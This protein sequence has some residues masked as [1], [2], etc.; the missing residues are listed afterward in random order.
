MSDAR[1]YTKVTRPLKLEILR[2]SKS[3]S[4]AIFNV[5]W[6]VTTDSETTEQYVTFVQSRFFY[7][8][9][10]FCVT[11]LRTWNGL[12]SVCTCFCYYTTIRQVA[13]V[14]CGGSVLRSWPSTPYGANF[15]LVHPMSVS[16]FVIFTLCTYCH[17][18]IS[19]YRVLRAAGGVCTDWLLQ[20]VSRVL[21][22]WNWRNHRQYWDP[23]DRDSAHHHIHSG[24]P[25]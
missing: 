7:I 2:F 10:S 13:A 8:C 24:C 3:S 12:R 22:S 20:G 21:R 6:Q 1:W 14:F 16:C 9:P 4:S 17:C 18:S 5:S 19:W 15:L 11:W 23:V 25:A